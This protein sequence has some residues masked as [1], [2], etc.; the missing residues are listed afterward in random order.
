MTQ[1]GKRPSTGARGFF[2]THELPARIAQSKRR[3]CKRLVC[4]FRSRAVPHTPN[5]EA[6]NSA[7]FEKGALPS[8]PSQRPMGKR[9]RPPFIHAERAQ[10]PG[11]C[12]SRPLREKSV[13]SPKFA[14][15]GAET[16]ADMSLT[17]AA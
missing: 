4:R 5:P 13:P 10:R 7:S 17:G 1:K 9:G 6:H 15:H 16:A 8:I 14:Q 3:R 2:G 11:M 12:A